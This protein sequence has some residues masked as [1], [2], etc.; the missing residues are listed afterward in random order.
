MRIAK[1]AILIVVVGMTFLSASYFIVF[2]I[3]QSN[4]RS[5]VKAKIKNEIPKENLIK[6]EIPATV[7]FEETNKIK[8]ENDG[9]EVE[10]CGN[11]YDIVKIEK[12]SD[13]V[14]L[15]LL[16]DFKEKTLLAN[17]DFFR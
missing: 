15:W 11:L 14:T 10:I 9:K 3:F 13:H 6:F 1:L 17:L 16:Q 12:K 4:I 7:L 2:K 8:W 5:E